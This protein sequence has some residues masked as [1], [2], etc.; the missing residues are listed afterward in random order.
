MLFTAVRSTSE[1][2]ISFSAKMQIICG[3]SGWFS[4]TGAMTV[5][6][7]GYVPVKHSSC[8]DVLPLLSQLGDFMRGTTLPIQS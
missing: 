3:H 5:E 8:H 6:A 7:A 2:Q 1:W 4:L